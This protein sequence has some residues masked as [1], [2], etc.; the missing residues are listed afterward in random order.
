ML[1]ERIKIARKAKGFTQGDVAKATG[2]I[3]Q[4]ALSKIE[5]GTVEPQ[6]KTLIALARLLGSNFGEKWLDKEIA[7][8]GTP[9][10]PSKKEV[11]EAM[12]VSEFLSL[13]FGGKQVRRSK[14]EAE[15]LA[16]L[17]DAEIAR[18]KEEGW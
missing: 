7:K 13:K 5:K 4:A 3:T 8:S 12:S 16:K 14:T 18:I 1:G 17:L 15:M 2:V 11:V 9:E 6:R 10:I